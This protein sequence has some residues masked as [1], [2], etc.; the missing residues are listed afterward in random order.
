[1]S[2]GRR[3]RYQ[4][5]YCEENVWWLCQ[6]PELAAA[7]PWVIFVSNSDRRCAFLEQRAAAP[8]EVLI[9]DYHVVLLVQ[10]STGAEIWDLDTRLPLPVSLPRYLAASFPELPPDLGSLAPRFRLVRADDLL[11][12]LSS[13]RSHM[14]SIGS[15]GESGEPG[16]LAPPP[17]WPPPQ[18]AGEP[19]N[20]MRFVDMEAGWFGEVLD[21]AGLLA[22]FG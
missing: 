14:R 18:V 6:E 12:H 15:G 4:P 22:R 1:M 7:D 11:T 5:S 8:G 2:P 9:W 10:A 17:P 16:W 21:R 13:D 20:L 3:F 19:T